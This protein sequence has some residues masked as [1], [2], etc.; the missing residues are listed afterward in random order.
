MAKGD[1]VSQALG[2]GQQFTSSFGVCHCDCHNPGSKMRHCMPCCSTMPCGTH[3]LPAFQDE[4]RGDCAT[5]QA[6]PTA[7]PDQ[8]LG[9]NL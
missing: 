8:E 2:P 3:V 4:H 1:Q 7:A 9:P 6:G 5:C